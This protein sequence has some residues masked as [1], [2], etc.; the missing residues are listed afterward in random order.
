MVTVED[1]FASPS[2]EFL[3]IC[4]KEQL[5]QIAEHYDVD[6]GDKRLK[7]RMKAIL[8]SNLFEKNVLS[9]VPS[10][11]S[12]STV[13]SPPLT[14]TGLTFD[15]QKELLMLQLDHDKFKLKAEL[16]KELAVERMRQQTEQAKLEMEQS[17]LTLIKEGKLS[18]ASEL[19]KKSSLVSEQS[20]DGFDVLGNL[21][22]LPK[23]SEKDPESFFA[24]FERVA[25]ARNWPDSARTLM[26]QCVLTGRA[27]EAYSS[28]TDADSQKY[29]S[30]KSAVLKAYELVPEAYRQRFRTWK[31]GDKQSHLEFARDLT[32]YFSRW[33]AA[34]GIK[35]FEGLC[36]LIVLEQFKSSVSVRVATYISEQKVTNAAAAAALA[37]DYVLTHRGSFGEPKAG[38]GNSAAGG[39]E[40]FGRHGKT[41]QV[42]SKSSS[43]FRDTERVCNYC[44]KR[45]HWKVDCHLLKSKPRHVDFGAHVKGVG[46]AAPV[47]Q[48][49]T[50]D[51]L[52]FDVRKRGSCTPGLESYLPFIR[53]GFV[54]MVGGGEKV[55][56]TILR[57]TG[58]FDSF[59]RAGVLPLGK[60]TETGSSIP[61]RGMDLNVLL[62]PLHRVRLQCDL[63]Q[64]EAELAV[65]PALPIPGV[66]VILGNDLVGARLWAEVP[67]SVV[68][69]PVPL[70]RLEPDENEREFP[71]VFTACAV[72]RAMA[73]AKSVAKSDKEDVSEKFSLPLSDFP[74][75]ISR[76]DLAAEQQADSSL[77]ELFQQVR[78]EGELLDSACGYFLQDSLLVRKWVQHSGSFVGDPTFQTVVPSKLR[79]SV[80]K[81]AHD[82]S[83]HSGVR[84]TYDR[85][86]RHFFW[87]RMK[88]DVSVFIKTCHTCQLTDKPN[89]TLKPVPLCPIPA[90]SQPFEHLVIDCVGPL[91]RSKSGANYLLTIMCQSTRYPAAYPLRTIT[92]RSV[93][94]ALSQFISIFGIP[95]VIQSDQGS[96]FSSCMFSQVLKQLRVQHNQSSAYHPQS[97]GVL[98]RFHQTLKSILRAYCTELGKD[99]EEGLPWLMLAAREVVQESTGFSPNELVFA[100]TV[101]GPLAAVS[102]DWKESQPPKNLID[103]I[104]GFRHRLYTA[105]QLAKEKLALAQDKM[106]H[107]YDRHAERRVFSPGDQVLALLP[108]V[109]SPFQAKFT[110]PHT[111]LKRISDQNYV[112]STPC[113]RKPVQFCHVN[114]LKPYYAR[115]ADPSGVG[116]AHAA[117][118]AGS[119]PMESL[120]NLQGCEEDSVGMPDQ[121]LLYGRLKNSEALR[122]IDQLL[123]HLPELRR[124]ELAQ[125]IQGFPDLFGDTPSRTHLIEHDID[126]G[127]AKPIKQRFY[128]VNA[129][130]RKY[131]DAEVDYMLEN[132]IAEPCSSSWSSPCLLVPKSDNTPRF[133][134]D[135]RKVN[136]VTK[137]DSFPLPRMEDCV[138]QVGAAKFVSKFDLLKGYWQVPLT[139]R[140]REIAAFITPT[141]LY[142][143][144]VMPFGL[145]NA[146]ATF[147]RLMNRVI[148]DMQ[149]CA[150][151]LD[152]VVVYSETWETHLERIRELFTRLAEARLTVN[153]AKCEFAR[154][155][156]TYLGRVVGQGQVRPVGAK[157]QAVAQFPPPTTKKELMRFLGLV[158]YYRSFCRNF[159][160][161]VAPLTDLLKGKAKFVWSYACKKAFEQVKVLLCSA[162]ILAAPRFD[163]PF[164]LYVDASHVGAGSVLMQ[165]DDLGIDKPVSY[166]SKKFNSCQLNYS[167][168]EKEALALILAL[169]HFD[170]YVGGSSTPVVV[171]TDHN[172]LTFLNSLQCPNQRLIRWSLFLQSYCLDIRYVKGTDNVVADAL[173]RVT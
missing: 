131:L 162:P 9:A 128:R 107:L 136:N 167:V 7:E 153:L 10:A 141:G 149:G 57:D 161:V 127:D 100:H 150:V 30:V 116:G 23:F 43:N 98:E 61:V 145:R 12:Q 50:P 135:F 89:Q 156:V 27:Q 147:Q 19:S 40:T 65:R 160:T 123:A 94:R 142:S 92:T 36:E 53:K 5:L 15:Q 32:M 68:V 80:L 66:S 25:D 121:A 60:E 75:S 105:G 114:L 14:A 124:L 139:Q 37:D 104:N 129:E 99:W 102:G 16:E 101:R 29:S 42:E 22:L 64:G 96:N 84:K 52:K 49:M 41:V 137:P 117:C 11:V 13:L 62:V 18:A 77:R 56:V 73:A 173:S 85:V 8:K 51:D 88:K 67:P 171:Y 152:D 6:V 17:R 157:V 106:K 35:D 132:G 126:I 166:F 164:K 86:L 125:L 111:V 74:V 91:P 83:G 33:C 134:S 20:C 110:G 119:V 26:L 168:I 54:S 133:C 122:S 28:L 90:I 93:V 170:V 97:Q 144:A 103:Y 2:E 38:N 154:A 47:P 130:K 113:R 151:Y 48:V 39:V 143:Y 165:V 115:N 24:L 140:A 1:F 55:P 31:K 72:T 95:K 4:T 120:S 76:S 146:P 118:V 63:F 81:V 78:P 34:S 158:G 69:A 79:Q 59:I 71:E 21:R 148:G 109:T 138:D 112:I 108:M 3:D 70:V 87:P 44:H 45:G 58:A 46:L 159:S 172:P 155:T 82:E 163:T 169:K